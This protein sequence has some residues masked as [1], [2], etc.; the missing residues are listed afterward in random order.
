MSKVF[1]KHYLC[2][3]AIWAEVYFL[4]CDGCQNHLFKPKS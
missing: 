3:E 2:D 4:A 1:Y